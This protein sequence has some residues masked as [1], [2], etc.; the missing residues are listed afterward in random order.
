MGDLALEIIY[1]YVWIVASETFFDINMESLK[2]LSDSVSF[3]F[4]N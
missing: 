1:T 3:S 4:Q 2:E